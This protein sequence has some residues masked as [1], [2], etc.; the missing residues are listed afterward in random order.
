MISWGHDF[1][2]GFLEVPEKERLHAVRAAGFDAVMI[3]WEEINGESACKRYDTVLQTGLIAHTVHFPQEQTAA[4]WRE[5]EA[6]DRLTDQAVQ[7]V[8]EIGERG[9]A[10]MVIHTTRRLDTPEPGPIGA[11]RFAR[12]AEA[13]EKYGVN[14]AVENTRFLRYNRYLFQKIDSPRLRFCY[15]CGHNHCFTPDEDALELFGDRLVTTHLHDNHGV[16]D[17]HLLIGEGNI[18][19]PALFLRLIRMGVDQFNLESRYVPRPDQEA[20]TMEEYLEKAYDRLR[21]YTARA[22]ADFRAEKRREDT[23]KSI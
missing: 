7:A 14:I 5:D 6:G 20:W 15:D 12:I 22:N 4:F 3:H 17:E 13:G 19:L 10:H 16:R 8:R 2:F 21:R 18:D 11:R 1:P 9:I 23:F